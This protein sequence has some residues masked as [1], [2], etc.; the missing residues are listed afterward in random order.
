MKK[1][2]KNFAIL[3]ALFLF[4]GTVGLDVQAAAAM[5][6]DEL[7]KTESITIDNEEEAETGGD[8]QLPE[9]LQDPEPGSEEPEEGEPG[10]GDPDPDE[11]EEGDLEPV[12]P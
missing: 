9:E 8:E 3:M 1:L 10:E 11:P 4:L 2:M 7:L 12:D 5:N 6:D